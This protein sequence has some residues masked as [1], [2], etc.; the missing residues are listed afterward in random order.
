M[1][2]ADDHSR[3]FD[4]RNT[5]RDSARIV[6]EQRIDETVACPNDDTIVSAPVPPQIV[7]RGKLG[8]ALIVEALCDKYIEHLPIERQC[9]RFARTG[10]DI[11]PQTL[12]RSVATAIDLLAPVSKLIDEQT[13]GPGCSAPTPPVFRFSIP[14]LRRAFAAQRCGA[15]PTRV[16]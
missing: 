3:A 4:L 15:G 2:R 8:D 9:T 12:G 1:W 13:R 5:Q 16:G 7:E 10:V 11:A 6:V 14:A